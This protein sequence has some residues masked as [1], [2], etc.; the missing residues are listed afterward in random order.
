MELAKAK[1]IFDNPN[2]DG[3]HS[4]I[5]EVPAHGEYELRFSEAQ[6]GQF[7][8]A[9]Q[10]GLLER[11]EKLV[12]EPQFPMVEVVAVGTGH[13]AS[14]PAVRVET[15]Q[16][17]IWGLYGSSNVLEDMKTKLDLVIA[18]TEAKKNPH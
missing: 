5:I 4:M 14:H 13:S 6:L 15:A 16:S 8:L 18:S 3:S 7:L 17:G 12:T 1:A 2:S 9:M 10:R 11:W